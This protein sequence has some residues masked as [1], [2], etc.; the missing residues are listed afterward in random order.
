MI[1]KYFSKVVVRFNPSL[2]SG[3][4]GGFRVCVDWT[5]FLLA[6]TARMFLAALP[7]KSRGEISVKQTILDQASKETPEITVQYSKLSLFLQ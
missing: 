6:K 5:N 4:F 1:T 7:P 3:M 2:K